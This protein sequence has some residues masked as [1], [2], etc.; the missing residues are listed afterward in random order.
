MK[1]LHNDLRF[2]RDTTQAQTNE[3]AYARCALSNPRPVSFKSV[4]WRNFCLIDAALVWKLYVLEIVWHD[5]FICVIRLNLKPTHVHSTFDSESLPS[6][7][8]SRFSWR[9][10]EERGK[11]RERKRNRTQMREKE[12]GRDL[13]GGRERAGNEERERVSESEWEKVRKKTW[14]RALFVCCLQVFARTTILSFHAS[15]VS[16]R[17]NNSGS[18]QTCNMLYTYMH[19]R[20]YIFDICIYTHI[21]IYIIYMRL[22]HVPWS[23]WW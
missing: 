22:S 23:N 17:S 13:R 2:T 6:W 14:K 18:W 7:R 12:V 21:Y 9:E 8:M 16:T 15:D 11:A 10:R 5:S 3:H 4:T 20:I 19:T 1:H